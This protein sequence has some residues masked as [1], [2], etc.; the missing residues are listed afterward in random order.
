MILGDSLVR[1]CPPSADRV[2]TVPCISPVSPHAV[3]TGSAR[4]RARCKEFVVDVDDDRSRHDDEEAPSVPRQDP[5][6]PF[7]APRSTKHVRH[8]RNGQGWWSGTGGSEQ[9][10]HNHRFARHAI[11]ASPTTANRN[12]TT[13]DR[14]PPLILAIAGSLPTPDR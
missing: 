7:Q 9:E 6:S 13:N 5:F 10:R 14:D 11:A 3:P 4:R 8:T 2:I 12:R 1:S